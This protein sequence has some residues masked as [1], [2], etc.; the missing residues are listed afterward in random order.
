MADVLEEWVSSVVGREIKKLQISLANGYVIAEVLGKLKVL[1]F[2]DSETRQPLYVDSEAA[3]S[4]NFRLLM[5]YLHSFLPGEKKKINELVKGVRGKDRP[6]ALILTEKLRFKVVNGHL[7][8]REVSKVEDILIL[9]K[10]AP[11]SP[12]ILGPLAEHKDPRD[13]ERQHLFYNKKYYDDGEKLALEAARMIEAD[14]ARVKQELADR[15]VERID[16]V[17]QSKKRM[18][19]FMNHVEETWRKTEKAI[20]DDERGYLYDMHVK[21]SKRNRII[22]KLRANETKGMLEGMSF[23]Q[24]RTSQKQ[25][26]DIQSDEDPVALPGKPVSDKDDFK[27]YMQ[28]LETL[29]VPDNR[30]PEYI[31]EIK[32]KE[33]VRL[34]GLRQAHIDKVKKAYA[35]VLRM[36]E[37]DTLAKQTR[38]FPAQTVD[39]SKQ[40]LKDEEKRLLA[41]A[42]QRR[43]ELIDVERQAFLDG[44]DFAKSATER[45]EELERI[46][47]RIRSREKQ[48]REDR[49]LKHAPI[50]ERVI[51]D[52]IDLSLQI[53]AAGGKVDPT[54][55]HD[56]QQRFAEQK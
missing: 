49:R 43:Q 30:I 17:H 38:K 22:N 45:Y 25:D 18:G 10:F 1:S 5:P 50:C 13:R 21:S 3:T 29:I 28:R 40:A 16:R 20:L 36:K 2:K 53:K 27:T 24:A 6:S 23:V 47:K 34:D 9:A 26:E 48:E 19:E 44:I 41:E 39:D 4:E 56:M 31:Q 51:S 52:L 33:R 42:Q 46:R 32:A 12:F 54:T 35:E 15:R 37:E 55:W 11:T 7:T 8:R 14:K